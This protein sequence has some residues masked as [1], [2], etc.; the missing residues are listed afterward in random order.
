[1][2]LVQRTRLALWLVLIACG[3]CRPMPRTSGPLPHDAYVWQRVW[4]PEVQTALEQ[5]KSAFG[6]FVP[7]CAEVS[8]AGGKTKVARPAIDYAAL[9]ATDRP[10]GMALRVAPFPGPFREDDAIIRSI[11]G[12]ARE[13]LTEARRHGLEP[14]ELQLD[15]DCAE[16]KLA[17]YRMWLRAL[18]EAVQPLPVCPTVLPS[19]LDRAE[20]APLARECARFVLQVHSVAPPRRP[21]DT[22]R[23][24]DPVRAAQ[25]MEQAARVGVP[26]R[27]ALPTYGYLV[28]FDAQGKPH[29]ISAEGASSRW[30]ADAQV[31]RWEAD[32]AELAAL[33]AGWTRER[34]T[35]L[36]GIIWY[37]LPVMGDRLNWRWPT[38]AAVMAG[39]APVSRWHVEASAAQPSE[40]MVINDGERDEPLPPT[41]EARWSGSRLLAADALEGYAL[42]SPASSAENWLRFRLAPSAA[43][44][45]LPPGSRRPIGW[46][47]CE[48]STLIELVS[49]SFPSSAAHRD[50]AAAA[51]A[52]AQR[53]GF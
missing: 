24:T 37:R 3:G 2:Q 41:I 35:A 22:R 31:L 15:F 19:W 40:I 10:V 45:R 20:F 28:A 38:L 27:V 46:I 34:P 30:P 39:R 53:D 47:R 13:C 32:P 6:S 23:L 36:T 48:E 49:G 25:W 50:P 8:I 5:G 17:G 26:F 44:S 12:T 21:E 42:E 4:T 7:L 43:L 18:R 1:M 14:V 51:V 33:V 29:G 11:I 9:R 16:A 52:P